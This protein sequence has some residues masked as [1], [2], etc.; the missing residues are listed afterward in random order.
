MSEISILASRDD[1][2]VGR[3]IDKATL[4][5]GHYIQK[6]NAS[7]FLASL[8]RSNTHHR[9][10]QTIT[11]QK[12]DPIKRRRGSA[13][14]SEGTRWKNSSVRAASLQITC[15]CNVKITHRPAK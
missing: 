5:A 14:R 9:A 7:F 1:R 6:H 3:F 2:N 4:T 11:R 12:N 13:R 10:R 8:P 15:M